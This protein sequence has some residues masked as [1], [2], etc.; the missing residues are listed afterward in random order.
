MPEPA[1]FYC[2]IGSLLYLR[3]RSA[4]PGELPE[5]GFLRVLNFEGG[6]EAFCSGNTAAFRATERCFAEM[7]EV[8]GVDLECYIFHHAQAHGAFLEEETRQTWFCYF[9]LSM[10]SYPFTAAI[11]YRRALDYKKREWALDK[12]QI[13]VFPTPGICICAEIHH[14]R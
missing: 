11:F 1:L 8:F 9:E 7:G 6:F 5:F 14:E 10:P 13:S 2:G 12:C 3:E 4:L